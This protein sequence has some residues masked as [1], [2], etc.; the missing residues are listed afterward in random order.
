MFGQINLFHYETLMHKSI[1][2]TGAPAKQKVIQS[3]IKIALSLTLSLID[4]DIFLANIS[5]GE[6][7]QSIF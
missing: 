1:S 2:S 7:N 5:E 6:G 4:I 3:W